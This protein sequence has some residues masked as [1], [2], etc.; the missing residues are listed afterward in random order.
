MI[1][2]LRIFESWTQKSEP[3]LSRARLNASP[4]QGLIGACET[5]IRAYPLHGHSECPSSPAPLAVHHTE[6]QNPGSPL[7]ALPP[8]RLLQPRSDVFW[9]ELPNAKPCSDGLCAFSSFC[10]E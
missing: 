2:T 10:S 4:W 9:A 5:R 3:V 8:T 1:W 7:P 6:D